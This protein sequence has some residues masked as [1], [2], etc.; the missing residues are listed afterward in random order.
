MFTV[1]KREGKRPTD[2]TYVYNNQLMH[3][4]SL[5]YKIKILLHVSGINS[6]SSTYHIH[7]PPP[8]AGLLM[9]ETCRGI[10]IL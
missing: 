7:M 4:L 9:P 6:P 10:L 2:N 1:V 3:C 8:D 5:V